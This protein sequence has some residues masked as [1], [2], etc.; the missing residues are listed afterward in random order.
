MNDREIGGA[1]SH[2]NDQIVF[3]RLD[4][5]SVHPI[6]EGGV[7]L[8]TGFHVSE[9]QWRAV[10]GYMLEKISTVRDDGY[11]FDEFRHGFLPH[12]VGNQ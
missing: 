4:G 9:Q 6:E 2:I 5:G 8:R 11:F 10:L 3:A 7:T 12:Y 1:L